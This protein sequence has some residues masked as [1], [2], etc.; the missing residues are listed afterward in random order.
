MEPPTS[1]PGKP[2]A[3]IASKRAAESLQW[4]PE[5]AAGETRAAADRG[6][7]TGRPSMEPRPRGRGNRARWSRDRCRRWTLQWS[8]DLAAGETR[9]TYVRPPGATLPFN[10]APTSRPGKPWPGAPRRPAG[11]APFNGAP[12]SRPGTRTPPNAVLPAPPS[13]LQWSP[14]LAAGETAGS[15]V[16]HNFGEQPSMEPD[17]KSTRLNSS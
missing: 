16:R 2:Q 17:R 14:D 11:A 15:P 3:E 12:T 10:G 9:V 1:P 6:R 7:A 4:S 8:P 13:P 5:L